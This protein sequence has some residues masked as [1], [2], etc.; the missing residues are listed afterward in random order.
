M[1][2][3]N[4][5]QIN[6]F[7][8]GMNTDTSDAYLDKSAYRLANNLRFIT[9]TGEN[10]GELHMI[11][12]VTSVSD[13]IKADA[14]NAVTQLRNLG[15]IV[16]EKG[17]TWE[18]WVIKNGETEP[19]RIV[20]VTAEHNPKNRV[21]G[22]KVSV[23]ARYEDSDNQK[24]YIADGRGPIM[25]VQ[26]TTTD[27]E[28]INLTDEDPDTDINDIMAYPSALLDVPKFS[29][30]A[31]G[32]LK[33]G[34]YQYSYQMYNKHGAASE[35]STPTKLIP[36]RKGNLAV[37]DSNK[38]EGYEQGKYTDKG[39]NITIDLTDL[40]KFDSIRI[41]RIL[42]EEAGQLPTVECIYDDEVSG[43]V[44]NYTDVGETALSVHT[45]EEYNSMTGIHIIPAVIESKDD[46]MFAANIKDDS[47]AEYNTDVLDWEADKENNVSWKFVTADLIGDINDN[48]GKITIKTDNSFSK[49]VTVTEVFTG[50]THTMDL[51]N[52]IGD[53]NDYNGT[54]ANAYVTYSLKSLRRGETYRYGIMLYDKNGY[55]YAVKH[56]AD[57]PVPTAKQSPFF[58][59]KDG[60]LHVYPMGI[61]FDVNL[62]PGI[63]RYEIVR[64]GRDESD[65]QT[66]TQ[67]VL[68]RPIA[69]MFDVA[70]IDQDGIRRQHTGYPLTPT[71]WITT[72]DYF[73]FPQQPNAYPESPLHSN[74]GAKMADMTYAA[75]NVEIH[76]E[77]NAWKV[78]G[79]YNIFQAI[80]PEYSYQQDAVADLLKQ[81]DVTIEP[82]MYISPSIKN[83]P[84][85]IQYTV[86][87]MPIALAG[88]TANGVSPEYLNVGNLY[89]KV[90]IQ[91]NQKPLHNPT[92]SNN[93]VEMNY[94]LDTL[95]SYY[96]KVTDSTISFYPEGFERNYQDSES[97]R[98]SY[99]KL[100]NKNGLSELLTPVEVNS[101][102]F[103]E[104]LS[105]DSF[106]TAEEKFKLQYPDKVT[107]IGGKNFVN[108]VCNGLYNIDGQEQIDIWSYD[109]GYNFYNDGELDQSSCMIGTMMGPGGKCFLISL[110]NDS[111]GG[112]PADYPDMGTYLCNIKHNV[113]GAMYGGSTDNA[114]ES[115]IYR[116]YGDYFKTPRAFVFDGDCF[117]MPFEYISQ[118]KWYHPY[119]MNGRKT[120]IVYSIPM[121][122]NINL[123]Y[124]YGYEFSKNI[125][126]ASGDIT[127]IQNDVSNV[128]NIF[129]QD[130]PLYQYNATYSSTPRAVT[131]NAQSSNE[132]DYNTNLDYRVYH[133]LP[134]ENNEPVDSWLKFMS[135]DFLDVDNRYG[136]ITGLRRFHNSLIFWQRVATGIL[137]VNER[138][139]ITDDSNLPLILGTGD[140]LGRFDYLN[141]SNG[142][143]DD[144]YCDAQSDT[145]LYWWDY[146]RKEIVGYSGGLETLILSKVK[147]IQNILNKYTTNKLLDRPNVFFDK[148]FNE[149][150]FTVGDHDYPEH[151]SIAYNEHL[152]QFTSLYSIMPAGAI[153]FADNT[154]LVK[155]DGGI[156]K[157][158][159]L[160]EGDCAFGL[161]GEAITPYLKYIVNANALYTKVFDNG[162]FGGRVYGGSTDKERTYQNVNPLS[163]IQMTFSTP[164]KQEGQLSGENIDNSEYNFRY[165]IPRHNDSPWGDRLRGK[166]MQVEMESVSNSYDFSLQ[167]LSTKYRISWA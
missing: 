10:S 137:Q 52:F 78:E 116:S 36:L 110:A 65:M 13:V 56:I 112:I 23:V 114:K 160:G 126:G 47:K 55:P 72:Q 74:N 100:Y 61:M 4:T 166:T 152:G 34:V 30:L 155:N 67:C 123:A 105:W 49:Q 15:I 159:S 144:Q 117:I 122:T 58:E 124:T 102:G 121:E 90:R 109:G 163:Y 28:I 85:H 94:W 46:Y 73:T 53:V 167:F 161:D 146:D 51:S 115:S 21:L 136:P 26:L 95:A 24:L 99:V 31:N 54:Y 148:Q 69:K 42:Y 127:N 98:Y 135:G 48:S 88:F 84:Q 118:H 154:L 66:I 157:W 104:T 22:K 134:K 12:G 29:G 138:S 81:D 43:T 128:N 129:V 93:Y 20:R 149:A 106:A 97:S 3:E 91:Q 6:D 132:D 165:A 162:E 5:I 80:S 32:R 25:V 139:Q 37:N 2:T 77:P 60:K 62:P 35:I 147:F 96:H 57:I 164:L 130:K 76:D 131:L 33:A 70:S 14:I 59:L 153:T 75:T 142:M 17:T 92:N 133:S 16:C 19:R 125:D 156:R 64:C 119:L 89:A 39:I 7:S 158:N 63:D 45:L 11:E 87:N 103:P 38:I 86:E 82:I 141:T 68:S 140:V 145:T 101:V 83:I 151:G 107:A 41:Y 9:N 71:G 108:W 120:M 27:G 50:V 113:T 8:K 40:Q 150:I 111:L 143:K 1:A 44:F 18:V 79:N